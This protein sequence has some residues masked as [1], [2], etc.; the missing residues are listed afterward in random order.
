VR[1]RQQAGGPNPRWGM[2]PW[3]RGLVIVAGAALLGAIVS[4][5]VGG[6]PGLALGILVIA[7]TA[8]ATLA[9]E[10]RT[11]YRI[12]PAPALAYLVAAAVA[13]LINDRAVDT[14]RTAVVLSAAQWVANG[15][16]A[17]TV[18]TG[19][20]IL[21]CAIRWTLSRRGR[22]YGG[23]GR[24]VPAASRHSPSDPYSAPTRR[25]RLEEEEDGTEPAR[26][27]GPRGY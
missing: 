18:A 7:G 20:A 3:G 24:I 12:I 26:R 27:N 21:I 9:V 22:P 25:H 11:V 19:L 13:G 14:T 15:F 5:L 10:P 4:V 23:Y 2:L 6:Q 16:F 8:A 17:M 1:E